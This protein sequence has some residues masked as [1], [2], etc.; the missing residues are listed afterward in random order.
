MIGNDI[1]DLAQA[2]RDSNWQRGGFLEKLFTPHE[3]QLIHSAAD[4]NVLV[5]LLWSMKESAYKAVIRK[6]NQRFFAP[7]KLQC[8]NLVFRS[9]TVTGSVFFN[10]TRYHTT[11]SVTSR[12]ISTVAIA[13]PGNESIDEAVVPIECVEYAHQHRVIREAVKHH[14]A[15]CFSVLPSQIEVQKNR[16]GVPS[17]VIQYGTEKPVHKFL[18]LSH[19]GRY[20]AFVFVN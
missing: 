17:L 18:S 16:A 8:C 2:A 12:Y 7:P 9:E 13:T 20:G 5:W 1:V 4:P 3:Q 15:R 10:K 14:A 11:S 6:T 19:H